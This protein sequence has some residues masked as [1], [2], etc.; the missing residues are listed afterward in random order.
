MTITFVNPKIKQKIKSIVVKEFAGIDNL[1][2]DL[3]ALINFS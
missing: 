3:N 2:D 1:P